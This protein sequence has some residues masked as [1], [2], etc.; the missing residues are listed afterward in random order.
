MNPKIRVLIVDDMPSV[1]R[2]IRRGISIDP[3]IEVI[4]EASDPYMARD[5]IEE[6]QPD[7]MTLDVEMPRMN[8]IEFLKK[9]MPQYP[10][11]VIMVS[12]HTQEGCEI[13]L[14]AIENGA[15]DY[16]TKPDGSPESLERMLSELIVKIKLAYRSDVHKMLAIQNKNHSSEVEAPINKTEKDFNRKIIAIGSSTGGTNAIRYILSE[17][18]YNFPGIVIVQHMPSN[19]TKIFADRLAKTLSMNVKEIESGETLE[20]NSVYITPGDFHSTVQKVGTKIIIHL[21]NNEKVNN[22][23]PSADVLF[24]SIYESKLSSQSIGVILTG[25]GGDGARGLLSM[26]N[27]GAVTIGQDENTSV[28]YGMPKVAFDIGAVMNQVPLYDVSKKIAYYL[29][30]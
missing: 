26:K 8:G 21:N 15:F 3:E 2:V 4:A 25:M 6:L 11:P 20:N 1:R 28:V 23:R 7:V 5:K 24:H 22:H 16:V 9:L 27:S 30:K 19:F 10:M 12:G 14:E 17:M 13:T 29:K 18:K